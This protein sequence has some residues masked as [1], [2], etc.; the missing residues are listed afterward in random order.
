MTPLTSELW[1]EWLNRQTT[2]PDTP[3]RAFLNAGL[4]LDT[5]LT[6]TM[7]GRIHNELV[8]IW[9]EL[10]IPDDPWS[11]NDHPSERR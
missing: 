8:D 9:Q 1:A 2:D 10:H 6:L 3:T 5:A 7:L 11:A 4:S